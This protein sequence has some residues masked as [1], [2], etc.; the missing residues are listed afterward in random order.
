MIRLVVNLVI[1]ALCILIP[2]IFRWVNYA[3][4]RNARDQRF[5]EKANRVRRIQ[6]EYRTKRQVVLTRLIKRVMILMSL[7]GEYVNADR[8]AALQRSFLEHAGEPLT[9]DDIYG[10]ARQIRVLQG[11][12]WDEIDALGKCMS[13]RDKQRLLRAAI[14]VIG[15]ESLNQPDER[16]RLNQLVRSLGMNTHDVDRVCRQHD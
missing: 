10:E 15:A 9:Q 13:R 6:E 1:L 16:D 12:S 4:A 14:C 5:A 2:L 3:H 11:Q 7:D 8:V